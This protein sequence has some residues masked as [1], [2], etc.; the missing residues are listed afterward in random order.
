MHHNAQVYSQTKKG[1]KLTR[2]ENLHKPLV[3]FIQFI[4]PYNA[5]RQTIQAQK[6]NQR[7]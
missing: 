2:Q 3:S 5:G 4:H 7:H 1:K 6:R